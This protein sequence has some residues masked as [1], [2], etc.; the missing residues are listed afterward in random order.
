MRRACT[1]GA[2]ST[3]GWTKGI[4]FEVWVAG[5]A[6]SGNTRTESPSGVVSRYCQ[7]AAEVRQFSR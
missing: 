1:P 6:I 4:G 2:V 5:S 3:G 7:P